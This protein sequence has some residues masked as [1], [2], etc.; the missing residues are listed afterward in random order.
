MNLYVEIGVFY[1]TRL[2]IGAFLRIPQYGKPPKFEPA[3]QREKLSPK[4]R[5]YWFNAIEADTN[6]KN[7]HSNAKMMKVIAKKRASEDSN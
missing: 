5:K 4:E 3:K 2:E 6:S 7:K 1:N